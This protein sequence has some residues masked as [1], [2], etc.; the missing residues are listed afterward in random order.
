MPASAIN[1]TTTPITIPAMVADPKDDDWLSRDGVNST[2]HSII[3]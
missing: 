3:T 1:R 2:L